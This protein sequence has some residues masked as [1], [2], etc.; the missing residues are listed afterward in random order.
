MSHGHADRLPDFIIIGA[1]KAG[2]TSLH[3][4]LD[5]HSQISMSWP[6]ET[7]HFTRANYKSNLEWYKNC[8][9]DRPGL[10]GEASPTYSH[11][12]A[13]KDVPERICDVL[14][15]VKLIYLVRDPV[16]R[17]VSNYYHKYFN[18]TESRNI[19]RAFAEID[20]L[21]DPYIAPGRYAMQLERFM[22]FFPLSQIMIF[23]NRDLKQAREST[24]GS[25]LS[26]LGVEPDISSK[27]LTREI[28]DRSKSVRVSRAA[29]Y[30][31]HS[32]PADIG[33][34][35]LPVRARE[36]L[37]AA[38]R[39]VLSPT[40]AVKPTGLSPEMRERVGGFF[41]EDAARFRELTARPFA[42]WS[43]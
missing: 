41:R 6:K 35:L 5:Q 8:F 2:T 34:R 16:E 37:Y 13:C 43:V 23:D 11:F 28:K 3:Y 10:R 33:R 17:A 14:P 42:H 29:A 36:P 12:P 30:A 18:R 20:S 27:H 19:E 4:Y 31:S 15:Q 21:D 24:V 7:N 22:S 40:G 39:R 9:P 32:A 38:A 26:F 1:A 25:V